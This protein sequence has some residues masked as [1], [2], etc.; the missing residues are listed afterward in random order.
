MHAGHHDDCV[1]LGAIENAV[2]EPSQE[3]TASVSM[4]YRVTYRVLLY[5][6][7]CLVHELKKFIA[8]ACTLLLIPTVSVLD[9]R[10]SSRPDKQLH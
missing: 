5:R 10:S 1:S 6:R 7:Q 2:W 9:V 8:Q 3:G 4:D